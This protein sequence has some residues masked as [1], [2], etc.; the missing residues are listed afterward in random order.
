M[1]RIL[2]TG[3]RDWTDRAAIH[4]AIANEAMMGS[5]VVVHGHCP[6][7]ADA[8]ADE[9]VGVTGVYVERY[10]ADWERSCDSSCYHRPRFKNGK[11]YC[12]MAGHLRNQQMVDRGA[13]V[14]YAFPLP[15]SRG[16]KDCIRRAKKA[17]IKVIE[18]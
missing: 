4:R 5:I 1:R 18:P 9:W 3:S 10:P 12:P 13:D 7:G 6:S 14:C 2:I 16:T 15:D 8:I 17:G 11:P